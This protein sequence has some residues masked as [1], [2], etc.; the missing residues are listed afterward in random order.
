MKFFPIAGR[1]PQ[2]VATRRNGNL[3]VNTLLT[4]GK[5]STH[6]NSNSNSLS[7]DDNCFNSP[8][9][10]ESKLDV[11]KKVLR[12]NGLT[13][14][15]ATN[16][17]L[18]TT[19]SSK[20]INDFFPKLTG[21]LANSNHLNNHVTDDDEN[22]CDSV[23]STNSNNNNVGYQVEQQSTSSVKLET[24]SDVAA[25]PNAKQSKQQK[26]VMSA[27]NGS[28]EPPTTNLFLQEPVLKLDFDK[29]GNGNCIKSSFL[30]TEIK[31]KFQTL[32]PDE[33][34][35]K[36]LIVNGGSP[37][38][39][40]GFHSMRSPERRRSVDGK[41]KTSPMSPYLVNTDSNSCD[42]GVVIG[43]EM[44]LQQQQEMNLNGAGGAFG[45]LAKTPLANALNGRRRKPTTPH[46]ILCP[47]PVKSSSNSDDLEHEQEQEELV[48]DTKVAPKIRQRAFVAN[49]TDDNEIRDIKKST[50]TKKK[51]ITASTNAT[52][53]TNKKVTDFFPV[54]RSVRKTKKEVQA[55]KNRIIEQAIREQ[56]EE[57]LTIRVFPN[58]G[59]GVVTTRFFE[60]GEFV[61]EYVGDLISMPEANKREKLYA[62]DDNTGCYMYYFKHNDQQYW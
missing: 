27:A 49:L 29:T 57:G 40:N 37:P 53:G 50:D 4:N 44:H 55:E 7:E 23:D 12:E 36:V 17:C 32:P 48:S 47:S 61:I 31:T 2:R 16:K 24:E 39:E 13:N 18:R 8:K 35:N 1:R 52:A 60:R 6:N 54:R 9:R 11:Q 58:K 51:I 59:R 21:K 19:R 22:T 41:F 56:R 46:R 14:D 30:T 15:C 26:I 33:Y 62:K 25:A 42:S 45:G 28:A 3:L 43:T 10:K 34:I 5:T 38:L 20:T